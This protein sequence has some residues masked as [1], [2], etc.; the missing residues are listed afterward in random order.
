MMSRRTCIQERGHVG[1]CTLLFSTGISLYSE[2]V[3]P[4]SGCQMLQL[5]TD[6]KMNVAFAQYTYVASLEEIKSRNSM[7]IKNRG[8]DRKILCP[9]LPIRMA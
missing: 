9:H 6:D 7:K 4:K 1:V 5:A 8:Q 2:L 3:Y